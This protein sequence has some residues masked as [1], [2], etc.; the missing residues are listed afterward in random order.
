MAPTPC[1]GLPSRDRRWRCCSLTWAHR[2]A[3]A[4][5][6]SAREHALRQLCLDH[7]DSRDGGH[8]PSRLRTIPF[9]L[10][11]GL[12]K[13]ALWRPES[14]QP[15]DRRTSA[16]PW[17]GWSPSGLPPS[18]HPRKPGTPGG[19][20]R[21]SAARAKEVQRN[22]TCA[23]SV[24]A[25]P[26]AWLSLRRH[27]GVFPQLAAFRVRRDLALSTNPQVRCRHGSGLCLVT[28]AG[29][30]VPSGNPLFVTERKIGFVAAAGVFSVLL[31]PL[32]A[33]TLLRSGEEQPRD[34]LE[35]V[36]PTRPL[37]PIDPDARRE[38]SHRS[39]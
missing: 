25:A 7:R 21:S 8:P 32:S 1:C 38:Q 20:T 33:L 35:S 24:D 37:H 39:Q 34:L 5:K 6:P 28:L 22:R 19:R 29:T 16:P 23:L 2:A 15:R 4:D 31:F 11:P 13:R 17:M 10:A 18:C 27:T 36:P 9:A 26:T 12:S 3:P 14:R 30:W